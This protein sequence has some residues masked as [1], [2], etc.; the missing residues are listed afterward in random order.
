MLETAIANGV[1]INSSCN[2]L[3]KCGKCRVI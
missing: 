2:G 3:G 1:H